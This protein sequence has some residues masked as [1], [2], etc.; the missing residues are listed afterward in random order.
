MSEV[1]KG[2]EEK[3]GGVEQYIRTELGFSHEDLAKIQGNLRG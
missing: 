3:Y 1:V 2:M